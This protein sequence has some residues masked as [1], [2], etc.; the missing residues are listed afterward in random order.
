MGFGAGKQRLKAFVV[1]ALEGKHARPRQKRRVELEGRVLGGGADEDDSAVLH[2]GQEGILLRAVEAVDLVDEQEGT[3]AVFAACAR[4]IEHLAQI[5]HPGLD[6]GELLEMKVG[7]FGKEPRHSGLAGAGR[8]P[9]DHRAE[10]AGLDHAGEDAVLSE[11]MV[12]AHHLLERR[13][14]QAIGERARRL[15]R[16]PRRLEQCCHSAPNP[17]WRDCTPGPRVPVRDASRPRGR[18][19]PSRDRRPRSPCHC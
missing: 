5:S 15:L 18:R 10:P 8:S 12:L 11:K 14:T 4:R 7:K 16:Q 19:A 3:L 13:G 9:E 2:I 1:Q 17:E 6:G